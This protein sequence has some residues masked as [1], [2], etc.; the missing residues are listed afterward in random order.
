MRQAKRNRKK[1]QEKAL[2][3]ENHSFIHS[4]VP[5]KNYYMKAIIYT[6]R[7]W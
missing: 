7:T 4:G 5:P 2:A 3:S 6:Q 1:P